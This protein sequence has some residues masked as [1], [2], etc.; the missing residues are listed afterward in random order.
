MNAFLDRRR[1]R[2]SSMAALVGV[3]A[4]VIVASGCKTTGSAPSSGDA[5]GGVA[6]GDVPVRTMLCTPETNSVVV[7]LAGPAPM[8]ATLCPLGGAGSYNFLFRS[9]AREVA[10][11]CS[12]PISMGLTS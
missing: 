5:V 8:T 9:M 10:K 1:L 6:G 2:V 11:L 12:L 3:L 7:M 4:L